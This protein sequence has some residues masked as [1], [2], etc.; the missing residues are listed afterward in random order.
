MTT[1]WGLSAEPAEGRRAGTC[2]RVGFG[3]LCIRSSRYPRN[4]TRP[5]TD[6]TSPANAN[7]NSSPP[8]A[9]SRLGP[10]PPAGSH[11]FPLILGQTQ[12]VVILYRQP[13]LTP[14]PPAR[15]Q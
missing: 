6:G 10:K 8:A 7:E 9:N 13:Q 12:P 11:Q 5:V 3:D 2:F 1:G 14:Y 15:S 4:A